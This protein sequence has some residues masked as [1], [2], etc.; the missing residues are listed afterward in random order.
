[1]GTVETVTS[2]ATFGFAFGRGTTAIGADAAVK[3]AGEVRTSALGAVRGVHQQLT[4]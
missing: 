3:V 4:S 2:C 1:M